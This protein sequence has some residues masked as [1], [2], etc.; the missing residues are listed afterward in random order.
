M[1]IQE[2]RVYRKELILSSAGGTYDTLETEKVNSGE[3]ME[4]RHV[5]V[6]NRSNNYTRLLLGVRSGRDFHSKEDFA[7]PSANTLSSTRS[8]FIV[9]AE[10]RFSARLYGCTSGDDL[11]MWLEGIIW[12]MCKD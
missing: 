6:E 4:I 5:S 11:H 8:R 7:S 2:G 1:W 10:C 9:P 12:G 3:V